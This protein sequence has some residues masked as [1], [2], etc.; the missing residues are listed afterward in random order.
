M[1]ILQEMLL[2]N[3]EVPSVQH[4]GQQHLA[5][6]PMLLYEELSEFVP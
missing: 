1:L 3:I 4:F 2:Q 5:N 6:I